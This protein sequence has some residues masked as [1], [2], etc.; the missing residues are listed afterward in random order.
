MRHRGFAGRWI[1][2]LPD[3]GLKQNRPAGA[4]R[5]SGD[6]SKRVLRKS[7]CLWH[8]TPSAEAPLSAMKWRAALA[9]R[10]GTEKWKSS[11]NGFRSKRHNGTEKSGKIAPQLR[12][13]RSCPQLP[14]LSL[15]APIAR[16]LGN[17]SVE[18]TKCAFQ[19]YPMR[20]R[21]GFKWSQLSDLNRRPAVY[22]TAALPLS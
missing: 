2:I 12:D 10:S 16:H 11:P 6:R 3:I 19:S 4:E 21:W 22:K 7:P 13:T 8:M 1:R 17:C 20:F 9:C 18:H 5:V 14:D 15:F